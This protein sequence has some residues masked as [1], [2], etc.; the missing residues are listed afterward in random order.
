ML[1][2]TYNFGRDTDFFVNGKKFSYVAKP[3]NRVTHDGAA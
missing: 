2:E 1:M 3:M